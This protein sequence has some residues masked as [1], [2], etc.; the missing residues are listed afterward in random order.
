ML[1]NWTIFTYM[2]GE[3]NLSD[4]GVKDIEEMQETGAGSKTKCVVEFDSKGPQPN[5]FDGT[6]RYEITP[7]NPVTGKAYR[8]V[9]ERF[10]DKDSGDPGTL[11]DSLNW[12]FTTYP[13]KRYLICLWNHGSGFRKVR[14]NRS[15]M[16][17]PD[18]DRTTRGTIFSHP[19]FRS[20]RVILTDDLSGNS[21][22]MIELAGALKKAG[23]SETNK[24]QILGF[25]ARLMNMLE[26]SYEMLPFTEFI[27]GSEEE[28]PN[29]GWPYA[30][31]LD[32]INRARNKPRELSV[33]LVDNYKQ[34]YKRP[35]NASNYPVTQSALDLSFIRE[36]GLKVD[37]LA[38][39]LNESL[40]TTSG[41]LLM[42]RIRNNVQSFALGDDFDDYIDLGHFLKL[43]KSS[44]DS[45]RVRK[46]ATDAL[47]SLNRVVIRN[48]SLGDDVKNSNGLSI[49]FPENRR[50]Y[51][52]HSRMYKAL[53]F[54]KK[55][56]EW[57]NFLKKFYSL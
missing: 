45:Y 52:T 48:I 16:V 15:P 22:D 41:Q 50:K 1:T 40:R 14:S 46:A 8:T 19:T 57:N 25:D 17:T 18:L 36:L 33:R 51:S 21:M 34:F 12:V 31:D 39:A 9:I 2:A 24:V 54:T 35:S 56:K 44:I 43:C 11:V 37:N 49:W 13:S 29:E 28:E 10:S 32:S 20:D 7:K 5:G 27:V 42:F 6:I 26:V 23:L 4:D 53:S 38:I 30:L 55:Y 47:A 3:N